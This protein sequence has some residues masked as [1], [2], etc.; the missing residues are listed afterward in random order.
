MEF[1]AAEYVTDEDDD[2]LE[3][4]DNVEDSESHSEDEVDVDAED[5]EEDDEDED[6]GS[7]DSV[8]EQEEE[9]GGS[10]EQAPA[11]A[12]A[13]APPDAVRVRTRTPVANVTVCDADALGCGVCFLALRPPIFQ[14]HTRSH[15]YIFFV[16]DS[17]ATFLET[18]SLEIKTQCEVGHVV[19]SDCR[20]KL[21]ATPSGNKCHV[22]GVVAARGGYRRCHAMEHLLDCIRV[23][24]PYAAH[25][26]DATP[27]YHGKESHRPPPGVPARAVP[28]PRRRVMRIHRLHGRATGPLRRRTQLAVHQRQ[29][30]PRRESVQHQPP[31]RLQLRHPP[32][33]PRPRPR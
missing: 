28:L 7:D 14:V 30:G 24:C 29:Q 5:M 25:G 8:H 19:C 6:L 21:E 26:C 23:P 22:C 16:F 3:M 17:Y 20:V 9:E 15:F 11:M 32:R 4:E 33:R 18:S 12:A 13:P 27:P 31:R 1:E 10:H 2:E